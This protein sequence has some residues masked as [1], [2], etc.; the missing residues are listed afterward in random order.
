M[1]K[2]K[3]LYKNM[4]NKSVIRQTFWIDKDIINTIIEI[5]KKKG[6]SKSVIF[7]KIIEDWYTWWINN[8]K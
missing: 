7:R 1:N 5:S 8:Q 2:V 6:V 3:E 4:L